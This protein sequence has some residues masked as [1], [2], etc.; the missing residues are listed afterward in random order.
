MKIRITKHISK[1]KPADYAHY[2]GQVLV[3]H[4]DEK[5]LLD[6]GHAV[7]VIEEPEMA[8]TPKPEARKALSSTK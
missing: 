5:E 2:P 6:S 7:P 1:P 3:D 8:I 4:P